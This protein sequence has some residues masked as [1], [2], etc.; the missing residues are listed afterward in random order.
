MEIVPNNHHWLV[1]RKW[2]LQIARY[3][4]YPMVPVCSQ[5]IGS[6]NGF[7]SN[8]KKAITWTNVDHDIIKL[9]PMNRFN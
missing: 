1:Y 4:V 9:E 8:R 6:G 2:W 5:Y 3:L 7:V